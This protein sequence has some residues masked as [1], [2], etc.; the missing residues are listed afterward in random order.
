MQRSLRYP[1]FWL[2][3]GLMVLVVGGQSVLGGAVQLIGMVLSHRRGGAFNL[4]SDPLVLG[5]INLFA[6][7]VTIAVGLLINRLPLRRAFPLGSIRL[8]AWLAL[9]LVSVGAAIVLSEV[10]NVFRWFL[11]PPEFMTNLMSE[12]FFPQ[13]RFFSM[14]FALVV[15]APL[16]E[17]LL[18]RGIVLRGLLHRYGP[19]AAVALSAMLFAFMHMNPW[20]TLSAFTL[21]VIFAWFYL[22][23]GSVWPG[24]V[25]H[26]INNGLVVII[27]AAPFGWWEAPTSADL[28][29][30]EFQPWWLDLAGAAMFALGV[31][32]FRKHTPVAAA[33]AEELLPP[34]L[35]PED[36]SP[37]TPA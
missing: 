32:L 17:E 33:A 3:V 1:G 30:V 23:T 25:G 7:G 24:V 11:P 29:L 37:V 4:V 31:W 8:A 10:D 13:G 27:A 36:A 21:G 35:P 9:P 20:Q 15:V 22:R 14:F 12:L 19:A 18:C 26:A 34:V 2:A 6:L 16:T 28:R 5:L